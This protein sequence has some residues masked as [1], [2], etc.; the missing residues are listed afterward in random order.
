MSTAQKTIFSFSRCP[1]KVVFPKTL[2]WN[3]I[4]LVLSGEM[5]FL[6]PKNMILQLGREMKDDLS[7]KNT[8]KY[9]IFFK[10]S[11]KMVFSKRATLRDMIFFVLSRKI[12]FFPKICYFFLGQEV[13]DYLSQEIHKNIFSVY[14]YRCY[15]RSATPL[16][17]KKQRWSYLAKIHLKVIEVLDWHPTKSSSNSLYSHGDL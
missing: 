15:K 7:Q 6:F 16:C 8:Q 12:V 9:N 1:E 14:M 17:R 5:I 10:L 3:M 13:R 2:Y 11:E 4:S